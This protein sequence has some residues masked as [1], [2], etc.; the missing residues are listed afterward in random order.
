[1]A[2]STS[3]ATQRFAEM[4][5]A[6]DYTV[7]FTYFDIGTVNARIEKAIHKAP[8]YFGTFKV[9]ETHSY[10]GAVGFYSLTKVE[11]TFSE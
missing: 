1:M 9:T 11:R 10:G 6:A 2:I 8:S 3:L 5:Q 4:K 7:E